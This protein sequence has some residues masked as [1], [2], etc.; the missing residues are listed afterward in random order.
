MVPMNCKFCVSLRLMRIVCD[1]WQYSFVPN[2][3]YLDHLQSVNKI[4]QNMKFCKQ[5]TLTNFQQTIHKKQLS[6]LWC[7]L[8]EYKVYDDIVLI[9]FCV[10]ARACVFDR[11]CVCALLLYFL[12]NFCRF[13]R[14]LIEEPQRGR[15]K[16]LIISFCW[17]ISLFK[18]D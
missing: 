17:I 7:K 11:V 9:G 6:S 16:T 10:R 2:H 12:S 14:K 15:K 1:R 18:M 13:W 8:M 3:F 5:S 4:R